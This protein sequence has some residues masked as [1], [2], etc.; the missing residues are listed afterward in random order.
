MA[1]GRK[2]LELFELFTPQDVGLERKLIIGK[3]SGVN[4]LKLKL[5]DLGLKIQDKE[6]SE[7]AEII[8]EKSLA[9]KRALFDSEI[10]DA[11]KSLKPVSKEN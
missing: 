9:L 11:Y 1:L 3:S 7:L 8:R 6:A 10:I 5:K 2:V 4:T